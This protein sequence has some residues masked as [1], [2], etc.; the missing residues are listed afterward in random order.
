[1]NRAVRLSARIGGAGA[2]I[3]QQPMIAED[4]EISGPRRRIARR[5]GDCDRRHAGASVFTTRLRIE[6]QQLVQFAAFD[7][8]QR[9]VEG[10]S[11]KSMQFGREQRLVPASEFSQL[12]VRDAV[13]PPLRLGQPELRRRQHAA[14]P[15]DHGSAEFGY[16]GGDPRYLVRVVRPGV[17]CIGAQPV[18]RPGLDPF[19]AKGRGSWVN[20]P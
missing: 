13:G 17:T 10:V 20:I 8:D 19:G 2:V 5:L 16:A 6:G 18:E 3:T 11:Q 12:V 1:M 7:A 15:G 9:Q 14:V 4:S